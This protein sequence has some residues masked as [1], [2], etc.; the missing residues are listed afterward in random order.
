[1][2]HRNIVNAALSRLNG[3]RALY[4]SGLVDR[5]ERDSR[6]DG[7]PNLVFLALKETIPYLPTYLPEDGLVDKLFSFVAGNEAR[8]NRII[9]DRRYIEDPGRL[10]EV[11]KEFVLQTLS[12]TLEVHETN[13]IQQAKIQEAKTYRFSWPDMEGD[14]PYRDEEE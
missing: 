5:V 11:T 14:F 12:E 7:A 13:E 10:A 8:L 3:E 9:H 1:M 4:F 6:L 2:V